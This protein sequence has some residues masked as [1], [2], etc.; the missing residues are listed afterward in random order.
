M[1]YGMN[2]PIF[3]VFSPKECGLTGCAPNEVSIAFFYPSTL[4]DGFQA[5]GHFTYDLCS[6]ERMV[7]GVL[8][9]SETQL[10]Q[11]QVPAASVFYVR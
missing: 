10:T 5:A 1:R 7:Q 4:A 2:E 9:S 3:F 11:C 6:M 8:G